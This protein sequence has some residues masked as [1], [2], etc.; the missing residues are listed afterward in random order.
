MK[1]VSLL[2]KVGFTATFLTQAL[3]NLATWHINEINFKI[4]NYSGETEEIHFSNTVFLIQENQRKRRKRD[5]ASGQDLTGKNIH[6]AKK[7][8]FFFQ[9][10]LS[11][12]ICKTCQKS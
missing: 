7:G 6:S 1:C 9:S 5:L 12:K 4:L 8:D 3:I 2:I 10:L 11:T